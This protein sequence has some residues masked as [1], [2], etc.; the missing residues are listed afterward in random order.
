M[1]WHWA[2]RRP[3]LPLRTVPDVVINRLTAIPVRLNPKRCAKDFVGTNHLCIEGP[4]TLL[5]APRH[6]MPGASSIRAW[7][8]PMTQAQNPSQT[9]RLGL[10]LR[11]RA[12][13][14]QTTAVGHK[15]AAGAPG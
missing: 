5:A 15:A 7:P 3:R 9:V 13:E 4:V 2:V 6:Q 11:S 14:Q 10:S 12:L 1:P 8:M